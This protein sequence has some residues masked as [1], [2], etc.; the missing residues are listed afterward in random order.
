MDEK[1]KFVSVD[2]LPDDPLKMPPP[3]WRSGGASFQ[4]ED[5]LE[6]LIELLHQL[7]P[8]HARTDELVEQHFI[9]YP[10]EQETESGLAMEEFAEI[11]DPLWEIEHKIKMKCELAILMS[12]IQ[13]EEEIN[14]FCVFNI[15]KELVETIEKLS[16]AEKLTAAA[17]HLG[18][19]RVRS[20]AAY[21]AMAE[22]SAWRN[23]FA[24]GH[25][26]DR[27]VKT[28]RHNHL[29]SPNEYPGV[30]DSVA[31][32]VK[33]VSGYVKLI[34]YLARVSQNPYT[35]SASEAKAFKGVLR[36]LKRFR[37]RGG[38]MIYDVSLMNVPS[39]HRNPSVK[40]TEKCRKVLL[41][42]P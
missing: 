1:A 38:P 39:I 6:L 5:A 21:S 30:P 20:T 33:H 36:D 8:I 31:S 18:E 26:V 24:H 13:G 2:Q 3:Y 12:A 11:C 41:K 19:K 22:L 32:V 17:S 29:I 42:K 16:P 35:S 40:E 7:L 37:F 27:P 25:C 34:E 14:R 28:L 23:A 15:P 9:K 4:V 10:R